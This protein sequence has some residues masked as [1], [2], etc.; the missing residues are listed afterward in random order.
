M[1]PRDSGAA[2]RHDARMMR[3]AALALALLLA[4]CGGGARAPAPGAA[5]PAVPVTAPNFG[6]TRPQGWGGRSPADYPVHGTDV[7]RFQP[8]VDWARARANGVNF[9][10]IKATEGADDTDPMFGTHWRAARAAGIPA[11]G[12]HFWYHCASGMAQARNFIRQVPRARGALPPVLDIEWTPTSPT[13]TRRTPQAELLRET[14]SFIN[15][16]RAHYGQVPVVYVTPDIYRDRGL[17]RLRGVQFWL[18]STAG[19]PSEVHPGAAWTFWQYSGTGLIPGITGEA[20]LN[21]FRGSVA[22]WSG[23]LAS[24]AR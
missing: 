19:H 17:G 21:L 4:A 1:T 7:S 3:P 12:Y 11:G 20:D 2:A 23:W 24:N 8:P 15:A 5:A 9:V 6:E 14:Q 10:F 18:R 16:V 13:C 22:E